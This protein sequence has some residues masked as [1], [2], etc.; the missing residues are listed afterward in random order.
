LSIAV[1]FGV[2][3]LKV[4]VGDHLCGLYAGPAQRDQ[5]L[6]P[7][8]TAGLRSGDKCIC[9]VDGTDPA[10]IVAALDGE[11]IIDDCGHGMG[12]Q[13]DV[14]RASDLYLRSGAFSSAEIIGSWKAAISDV[15]YDGRF[16]VVRAIETWSMRDVLP[17]I[18]ELLALESEM[19]RYLPLYP[20]VIVCLYD[21]DRFGGGI[22]VDLLKTHPRLLVGEMVLENPYCL[23]PDE[24][25]GITG[26]DERDTHD[27]E[28]REAAEWYYAVTTGLT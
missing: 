1:D 13:L 16:D 24:L 23:T 10:E 14:L 28:R 15:M 21:L 19:N 3:G 2:H 12:K 11:V 20:Q 8:L 7:F 25:L 5:V 17:D 26:R 22:V 4:G 18:D 27:D 9:V 6:I